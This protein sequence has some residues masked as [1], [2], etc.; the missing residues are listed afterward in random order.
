M[1]SPTLPSTTMSTNGDSGSPVVDPNNNA[2]ALN[3]AGDGL[4]DGFGNPIQSVLDAL[5]VSLSSVTTSQVIT[6]TSRYWF[7]HG[8]S[9]DNDTNCA[10]LLNAI[11]F[12][13]GILDLGFI[14]LATEDRNSDNVIDGTDAFIEALSF[15][16]RSTT[17]TGEPTGTQGLKFKGSSLC[18]ARK[19]LAVELIAAIANTSLLG[20]FPP[21]ATY[22]SGHTVTT[23]PA[24]L[25]SQARNAAAGFDIPTIQSM[26][27][28]L[29]QFNSSGLTNN[30]PNNLVE[31]SA[32][33][34]KALKTISRDPTTQETCPGVNTS[35]A[36][37]EQMVFPSS[38]GSF[39]S[40]VFTRTV[41]LN[42]SPDSFPGPACGTGGG[43]N[44]AWQI[45]P[46]VSAANRSFTVSTSDANFDSMIAVWEGNCSNLVAV[47][48]ATSSFGSGDE[49]LSFQTDG[50]NT[51]FIVVQGVTGQYGKLNLRITSP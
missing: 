2:V 19:K 15:Y 40:A 45:S 51:F 33:T 29:K 17:Q 44:A 18:T 39:T 21:N 8:Y 5:N 25:I 49:S 6:R 36:T 35:C 13:G 31:C 30:L 1:Y 27:I 22:V 16:W 11:N 3:F 50:V 9:S 38:A 20:T 46:P 43:P 26:T 28:L 47:T 48:C 4:G 14:L 7:T 34:S 42:N 24:D 41:A 23:F 10:T 32:Q 37:A 12:N